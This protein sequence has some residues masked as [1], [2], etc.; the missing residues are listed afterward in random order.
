MCDK[1]ANRC[2]L[3]FIYILDRNKSQEMCNSVICEDPFMIVDDCLAELKFILDQFV[4]SKMIKKPHTALYADDNI[5]YFNEDSG[6]V[7]LFCNEMG[8][9]CVNLNNVNLGE[10]NY[11]E[12]DRETTSDFWLGIVST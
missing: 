9:V 8:I 5:L 7:I 1:A 3:V 4:T 6:D 12:D 10:T 2:F 11:G